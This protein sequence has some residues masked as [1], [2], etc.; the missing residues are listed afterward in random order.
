MEVSSAL[1]A[2]WPGSMFVI[3]RRPQFPRC[4]YSVGE[5]LKMGIIPVSMTIALIKIDLYSYVE[6]LE[7]EV[8]VN[9]VSIY[10]DLEQFD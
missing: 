7:V 6:D 1:V 8:D 3:L 10:R 9:T 4:M 2:Q 5:V